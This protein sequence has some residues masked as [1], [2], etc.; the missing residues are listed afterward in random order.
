MILVERER[1]I[2]T[3]EARNTAKA[4]RVFLENTEAYRAL[5]GE[6]FEI[7]A[8]AQPSEEMRAWYEEFRK[9]ME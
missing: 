2:D 5:N 3:F 8:E 1:V 6:K 7:G 4:T 9:I